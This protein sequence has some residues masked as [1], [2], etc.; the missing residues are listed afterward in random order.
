M[1]HPFDNPYKE[2]EPAP[3]LNL[4][5]ARQRVEQVMRER[6][7]SGAVWEYQRIWEEFFTPIELRELMR[8]AERRV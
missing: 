3:Y 7:G 2:P 8:Q 1:P 5:E 4:E 6:G